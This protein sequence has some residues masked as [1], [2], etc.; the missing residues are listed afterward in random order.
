MNSIKT[1]VIA[2]ATTLVLGGAG[3][4]YAQNPGMEG[5]ERGNG[6]MSMMENCPMMAAHAEGPG[7]ILEQEAELELSAAQVARLEEIRTETAEARR[8][9]MATMTELHEQIRTA[10]A[11]G[12]FDEAAVRA[13]YDR[14]GDLHPEMAVTMLRARHEARNILTPAQREELRELDR[15][16][17][18][19]MMGGN[20]MGSMMEMMKQCPMMQGMMDGMDM[21]GGP[22]MDAWAAPE[23]GI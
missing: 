19:G 22:M 4:V 2:I 14:M 8:R 5:M 12:H 1:G 15:G 16:G 20:G 11:G 7:A 9:A 10:S 6:M 18:Q 21:R 3:V 23:G 13:A 17:M